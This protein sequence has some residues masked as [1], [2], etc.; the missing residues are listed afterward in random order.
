[1]LDCNTT[2][3]WLIANGGVSYAWSNAFYGGGPEQHISNPGNYYVTVTGVNGCTSAASINITQNI[4]QPS[5]SVYSQTGAWELNCN[6]STIT[7]TANS[8]GISYAWSGGMTPI[9][10]SNT[11]MNAGPYTLTVTG[12]NGCTAT[13]SFVIT[14]NYT[15]PSVSIT[16][17]TG[18]NTIDCN[19]PEI[20]VT[21]VGSGETYIWSDGNTSA[22]RLINAL[23]VYS[24][25]VT[26]VN[27]CTSSASIEIFE[28]LTPPVANIVNH[29]GTSHINCMANSITLLASGG[30]VYN[31]S[32]G[33]TTSE[34][35]VSDA[36]TYIVTVQGNNGCTS[37]ASASVTRAPELEASITNGTIS[38]YGGTTTASVAV[39]GG[40]PSY[41]YVWNSGSTSST[42]N[43][44]AAGDYSVT[45]SDA[46]GC[47][48]VLTCS[49][50][51]PTQV[52]AAI[53]TYD[54]NCGI[55]LGS[56]T[57]SGDGGNAPYTYMWSNGSA[58]DSISNLQNTSYSVT[59]FDA[60][61]CSATA[62]A[63][64]SAHGT[65]EVSA[66]VLADVTCFNYNDGSARV[67]C[68]SAI[69]PV[70]YTWSNGYTSQQISGLFAGDY[71]VS[72]TDAWGC[73]GS[74][75]VTISG[76]QQL[77]VQSEFV[78]PSC[79]NTTDGRISV[80]VSGGVG[81]Y[82]YSW[83]NS[84]VVSNMANLPGGAYSVTVTDA[85]RCTAVESVTL[86]QPSPVEFDV[87]VTDIACYGDQTGRIEIEAIGGYAPYRYQLVSLTAP[88]ASSE[89][90]KL[91]AGY[92]TIRVIDAR[93]CVA[94]N[95]AFVKQPE[96]LTV[97]T[98]LVDPFCRDSRTG[99]I[100]L[101]VN[102][103]VE[104][105]MYYWDN[106][107]SE[108]D[109]M[110]NLPRGEYKVGVIDANG[111]ATGEQVVNL[112]DVNV[113]CIRIPN[114]FT[115]NADGVN[116]TWEIEHI[117]MFPDAKIYVFNRWGQMLYVANG[118]DEPWDGSY[119]G[120]LV[121]AGVYLYVVDL[122]NNEKPY[123]G[124]VTILY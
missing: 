68:N 114:V 84:Q 101:V 36:G 108:E 116:D 122:F 99:E 20:S 25:T 97:A 32:E 69:E 123:Q 4:V 16:N 21:A 71:S 96:K 72:L 79:Y 111:C 104:P 40:D 86:T 121:P 63:S 89:F 47:S 59:V 73:V 8:N 54:I 124:S 57:A 17:N 37:S 10:V 53:S 117:D 60:N 82:Q 109:N 67:L 62:S 41:N 9:S 51:Q 5:L 70:I 35:S 33:S 76:P 87:N 22:T 58:T 49:I 102:G 90:T 80:S 34:I 115:P 61:G 30:V 11:F 23:G 91:T 107:M 64:I 81:P 119:K 112:H 50:P 75:S 7:V 105:Y 92:Y 65:L 48:M 66:E 29:T 83:S 26:A 120:K 113:D 15:V 94:V 38:C 103:G 42:A 18:T 12:D 14:S 77:L 98:S 28:D 85:S 44:L 100:H 88:T 78:D 13:S 110:L 56:M 55:S 1:Q 118:I 93:S 45:V 24:V 106:N 3:I 19:N 6:A 2:E 43:N 95:Q 74:A 39:S 46:G 52:S 31:W 27:G